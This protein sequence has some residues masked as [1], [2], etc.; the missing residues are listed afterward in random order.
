M[1]MPT[2]IWYITEKE[3]VKRRIFKALEKHI[4]YDRPL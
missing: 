2:T 4:V 1:Y 3:H